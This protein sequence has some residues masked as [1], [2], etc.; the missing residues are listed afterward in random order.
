LAFI[1]KMMS[2]TDT[3]EN[4]ADTREPHRLAKYTYEL[5]SMVHKYYA[6]ET[7]IDKKNN[8]L[9]QCRLYLLWAVKCV[10]EICLDLMGI[11]APDKM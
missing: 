6:K 10:L 1:K 5:A 2:L 3:L 11:S 9:T 7:I 8:E 4:I